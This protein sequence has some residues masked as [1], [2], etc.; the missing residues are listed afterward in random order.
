MN[1]VYTLKLNKKRELVVVS[2]LSGGV[3]KSARN[4]LLKSVVVLM[5][6]LVDWPPESPD[7]QYHLFK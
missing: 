7:N 3:K 1:F 4:K 5:T 2:E 6:T